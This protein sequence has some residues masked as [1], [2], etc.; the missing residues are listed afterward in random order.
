MYALVYTRLDIAFAVRMLEKYQINLSVGHQRAT[1]KVMRYLQ[2][3]KDYMLV[4][5]RTDNLELDSDFT[6]DVDS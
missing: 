6:S 1:K 4:Y 2:E 3:T 5:R